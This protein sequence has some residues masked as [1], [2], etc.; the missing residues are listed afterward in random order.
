MY[1]SEELRQRELHGEL[2][3]NRNKSELINIVS[4]VSVKL[5]GKW[6]DVV[7]YKIKKSV[8]EAIARSSRHVTGLVQNSY[9]QLNLDQLEAE[10]NERLDWVNFK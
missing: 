8:E 5:E 2:N 10:V 9:N 3:N 4:N 6:D 7:G 1:R